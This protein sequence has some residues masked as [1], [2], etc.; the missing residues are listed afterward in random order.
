MNEYRLNK[1]HLLE[2]VALWN[3]FLNRK[4]H[5]IACGGTALTLLGIK[6]ST[7]DVDFL[8]PEENEYR[9]L[10]KTLSQLGY[11]QKTGSGWMKKGESYIFDLFAG[12]RVHT[13]ELLESPLLKENHQKIK[14]LS[15]LYIGVLNDYD[16]IVSKLFR[17]TDVDFEDCLSLMKARQQE[18]GLDKLEQRFKETASYDI[19]EDRI[20]KHWEHFYRILKKEKL[21]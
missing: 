16:L 21:S 4:V 6:S 5:L 2:T 7:K 1:Q 8:V 9:Y 19:S 14:E 10:V 15:H 13:T 12:K 11:E 18:I 20:L 17:G 3:G